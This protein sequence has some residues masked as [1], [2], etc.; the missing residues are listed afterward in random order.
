MVNVP[1][2][3]AAGSNVPPDPEV[4]PVPVHVPPEVTA[5]MLNAP[6][7][8]QTGLTS[9]MVASTNA[10]TLMVTVEVDGVHGALAMLH[11]NTFAPRLR[12]VT[13]EVGEDGDVI[14]PVPLTSVH[15]PVPVTGA[16]PASVVEVPQMV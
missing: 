7:P 16:F 14:R 12:P 8:R 13:D 11:W 6:D 10:V 15:V 4:M 2:P 3:A 5:L 1:V 9:V